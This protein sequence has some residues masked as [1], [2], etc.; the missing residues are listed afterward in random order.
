M[1]HNVILWKDKE[2][3]SFWTIDLQYLEMS[4]YMSTSSGVFNIF[5]LV[6]NYTRC[7]DIVYQFVYLGDQMGIGQLAQ[8]DPYRTLRINSMV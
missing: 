5:T 3:N 4:Y 8:M 2:Q 1:F 6:Y 7:F